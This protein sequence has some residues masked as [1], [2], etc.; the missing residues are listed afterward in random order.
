MA[1]IRPNSNPNQ[2][3]PNTP[4]IS[5]LNLYVSGPYFPVVMGTGVDI[6]NDNKVSS[7]N[8][9][10]V[11][12]ISGATGDINLLGGTGISVTEANSDF[13][14]SNDGVLQ[15]IAGG[16][17]TITGSNGVYTISASDAQ[18]GTVTSVGTGVGLT[19]GPITTFG[20]ISLDVSGVSPGSYTSP[21][22]TVDAY[23][24]I[25]LA[26]NGTPP[27]TAINGTAPVQVTGSSPT[28]TVA[29]APASTVAPGVVQL[30]DTVT[31]T[32]TTAAAT[33]NAV[34][35]AYDAATA[36]QGD[37]TQALA[38]AAAAQSD[39]TQALADAAAAQS[40]AD[41][42]LPKAGGTMTGPIVFAPGQT[43]PV[44]GL[45]DATTGSKGVVQVGTNIGVTGG[46]IS[47][48]TSSTSQLGVVQLNDSTNSTSTTQA[49]TAAQGKNL[50]DQITALSVSSNI[51][52]GGT[53]N[54]NTGLVD[55]VTTQGTTAGLVVGSALPAAAPANNEIFVIVD[56]QGSTGPSGT[57]PYHIGDWYL[58]DGS[59]WQFLNVG[60]QPGQATTLSQGT[61]QLATDAQVQAGTDS[62]NAVVS[63]S[64]QSKLSDSV[65]TV[66]STAIASSTAVKTA[67]DVAAVALPKA[68]G[69]MTGD[70]TF[71][72][73]QTFPG[74]VGDLDF[75]AKGDLVAGFGANSFGIASV[76]T[77][78]QILY[79]CSTSASG[80]CWAA[81][82]SVAQAT[83]TALG[84]LKGR[85]TTNDTGLGCNVL[86]C[87]T[88]GNNVALGFSALC[89]LGSTFSGF[90]RQN[91][92]VGALSLCRA[93]EGYGNVAVGYGSGCCVGT[94]A[95][96][97]FIGNSTGVGV[98][99]GQNNVF[100]GNGAS[101]GSDASGCL[102]LGYCS[103]TA[104]NWLTG[105]GNLAIKP[106][107]G[108][109][110]CANSCGTNGQVLMSNGSNAICWGTVT[111]CLGT[112]T[113][114]TAG[115]GLT[116]GSIT[117]SG[118]IAL[119]TACVV[120]PS[121]FTAKGAILSASA[122]STPS[123]LS[124]GT[125]GQVLI[126]CSACTTGLA[127]G[128]PASGGIPC[129]VITAK[130]DIVV[131]TASSTPAV[132]PVGT[133]NQVLLADS[134]CATGL[135]WG[136]LPTAS[137]IGLGVMYGCATSSAPNNTSIGYYSLAYSSVT[138]SIVLGNSS[139]IGATGD[140]HIAIGVSIA[141][142]TGGTG[143]NV[144]IGN[145][146]GGGNFQNSANNVV[147]GQYA[148]CN[149][150]T[151]SNKNVII[152]ANAA[153]ALDNACNN[154]IIGYGVAPP[155]IGC[156]CTLA[157]GY[158]TG[159]HWLTGTSTKA[160]R[161]G[162]GIIDCAG[163]CGTAGQ[164]LMSN[165]S[166]AICWG[167]AGGGGG[168]TVTSITAGTGLTG[169]TIT[170]SGTVALDTACVIQPSALTAKGDL[171]SAS[172]AATPTALGVG[173]D[174][175]VLS[176][177][178]ACTSGLVWATPQ[179]SP[180]ITYTTS[181]VSYTSGTPLL[182]AKWYDGTM[183]GTVNLDLNGYGGIQQLWDFYLSGGSTNYNTGWYQTASYPA[184][185][186]DPVSQGTWYVDFPVYPSPDANA[187]MIYFSPSQNSLNPSSF[188]FFYRLLPGSS[189]PAFQ[190]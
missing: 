78:G 143:C 95:N 23:G 45:P 130:G 62:S 139:F 7:L 28:L 187:W 115:T 112:V 129:S 162:A 43:I 181:A 42:A 93:T 54:A 92:A 87:S 59:T 18:T 34:K 56:V 3:I 116:G 29:V 66:S 32:S 107:A 67:Y 134:G 25:T 90:R 155:A 85:L 13:T 190:I 37:A 151:G 47:V 140:S 160:I 184:S 10:G 36:A 145:R 58:S 127:W 98:I 89:N 183:Q 117:T 97:V 153:L 152:G 137:V 178:S 91:T 65:S 84:T 175:Q 50:Q 123:A 144:A 74:T 15:L 33:A 11:L 57:P 132:L 5:P 35:T 185:P 72:S 71:N 9:D 69:T 150:L 165:G 148:T 164:V 119:D 133:Y 159:C 147:I 167:T 79:A 61:V 128:A 172:A 135:K 176:A 136:G 39:A 94:G 142:P 20:T 131:G 122:A 30:D 154:V 12:D 188:T 109:I 173:T 106:G 27:I 17:I 64:L 141:N 161:P 113:D 63:S 125:D 108:I 102:I 118:T 21:D 104:Y 49:L 120:Q 26:A 110:D 53:F 83:P 6:N 38:D 41:A 126:A 146:I 44:T 186:S 76:G 158:D 77:D 180:F 24:R 80:L 101:P 68:G 1:R 86:L 171:L 100:I 169:G 82:P 46:V 14:I 157:I 48:N 31:S 179:T 55:S 22:I 149:C 170:D 105:N 121:A 81:A 4:F 177:C 163:S 124:V 75:Q 73:S 60:Y 16:N 99:N 51:V 52:L 168:G 103:G 96:N 2:P 182:V 111:G 138:C 70:I 174:G 114:I 8:N 19:G 88:G 156:D 166:N 189:T 40:T